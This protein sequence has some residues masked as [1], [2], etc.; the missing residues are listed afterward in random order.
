MHK[1]VPI[2][3]HVPLI[4]L[5][6]ET[7]RFHQFTFEVKGDFASGSHTEPTESEQ[8]RIVTSCIRKK[9]TT[10]KDIV[11]IMI[12]CINQR[13]EK[14]PSVFPLQKSHNLSDKHPTKLISNAFHKMIDTR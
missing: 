13:I 10:K 6:R 4:I 12:L 2:I 5:K 9:S 11:K 7:E 14:T 3:P 8:Y 1:D